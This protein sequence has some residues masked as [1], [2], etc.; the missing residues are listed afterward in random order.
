MILSEP[1][2][3][4]MKWFTA[5]VLPAIATAVFSLQEVFDITNAEQ[6]M[7]VCAILATFLGTVLG[8]SSNKYNN[9]D[10]RFDGDMILEEGE[11]GSTFRLN[12]NASPEDLAAKDSV[13]FKKVIETV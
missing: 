1:W 11:D 5:I 2:Y 9:S 3:S 8:I 7:G 12:L 13:T 4:R 10:D 6:I